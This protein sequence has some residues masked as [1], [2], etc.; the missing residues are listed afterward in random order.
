MDFYGGPTALL[1]SVTL[2]TPEMNFPGWV[3][4]LP[5]AGAVAIILAGPGATV[6]RIFFS[7]RAAVFVGLISYP[8]YLWHWPLIAYAYVIRLGKA[9]TPL[10]AAGLVAVS[11]LLAW[12]TY[13]FVE[14]PVRFGK[15]RHWR[16]QI[17]A[18]CVAALGA[19]GL[20]IW[21]RGGFP[22]RFPELAG[23]DLRK[24]SEAR[25][26]VTFQPTRSMKAL[27]QNS[28]TIAHLGNGERKVA[29]SGERR[30][31]SLRATATAIG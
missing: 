9:P 2:F 14:L 30:A 15:H 27:E 8:L 22:D 28:I 21:T 4:L 23:L 31:V 25:A 16:T 11:F 10:M 18:V 6:N 12:A 5:V 29:L 7:N 19:C 3:A 13:R 24:I 1:T 17:V 20:V 26:D